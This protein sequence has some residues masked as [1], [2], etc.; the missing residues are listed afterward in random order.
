MVQSARDIIVSVFR[1]L[2][3]PLAGQITVM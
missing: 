1:L 2:T 3:C